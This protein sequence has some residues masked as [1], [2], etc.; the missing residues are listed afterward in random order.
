M[1][2]LELHN[3]VL[4]NQ[5]KLFKKDFVK[6]DEGILSKDQP[7]LNSQNEIGHTPLH[8]AAMK[9]YKDFII[10][11]IDYNCDRNIL[12]NNGKSAYD[13]AIEN[14]NWDCAY[15]LGLILC[16]FLRHAQGWH[17]LNN[18]QDANLERNKDA[19]LT[20]L[21][22]E[23]II[24]NSKTIYKKNR[25]KLKSNPLEK[26]NIYFNKIYCSSLRRCILTLDEF[27]K[28]ISSPPNKDIPIILD[29]RLVEPKGKPADIRLDISEMKNWMTQL[30][31]NF[32]F[33][34]VSPEHQDVVHESYCIFTRIASFVSDL[35]KNAKF[36]DIILISTH[37]I[38]LVNLFKIINIVLYG[39]EEGEDKWIPN[40]EM[41]RV[42]L[43]KIHIELLNDIKNKNLQN[44]KV[45]KL[46]NI[47]KTNDKYKNKY[48]KYK[49]KYLNLKFK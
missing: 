11:L 16:Y 15:H 34:N 30:N 32:N 14:K 23:Q 38:W 43:S 1:N 29:D 7:I 44:P 47:C 12:D 31:R 9:G 36:N 20:P 25:I 10:I 17:N 19:T 3:I 4:N 13:L 28:Y 39:K 33:D 49:Q 46:F 48:L 6:Y 35:L 42:E 24:N 21:G 2:S 27:L 40:A 45:L 5:I 37:S 8:L 41:V 26:K 22:Y 18:H